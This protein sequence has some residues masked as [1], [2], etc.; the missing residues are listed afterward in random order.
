ME[1]KLVMEISRKLLYAGFWKRVAAHVI[2]N[3]LLRIAGLVVGLGW[4]II[5]G[6]LF[7]VIGID[8]QSEYGIKMIELSVLT[9]TFLM[10]LLYYAIF[11]SS[12]MQ[13]TPGKQVLKIIVVDRE[14]KRLSFIRA[15]GRA[16]I[17]LIPMGVVMV[18][19]TDDWKGVLGLLIGFCMVVA[20]T[21]TRQSQ[22]AHDILAGCL[23][24]NREF[25][26]S[27]VPRSAASQ[28]EPASMT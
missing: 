26:A 16:F 21:W 10:I 4:S 25:A 12:E 24:V 6:S 2:D 17:L 22:G 28:I 13:A 19:G 7:P 11:E 9:V 5:A 3:F 1:A 15:M 20:V 23:V 18:Y 27:L 14:L 8:V